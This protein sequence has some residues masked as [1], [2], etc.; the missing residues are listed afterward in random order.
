MKIL[1][2]KLLVVITV[3]TGCN[4]DVKTDSAKYTYNFTENSCTTGEKTFSSFEDYCST[5]KSN[6][7]NNNCARNLRRE[8]FIAAGCSG[9]FDS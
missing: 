7:S 4:L 8:Q 9:D 2:M 1:I 5:L 3:F 6:E